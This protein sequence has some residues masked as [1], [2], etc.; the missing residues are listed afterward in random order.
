M[1]M[2]AAVILT[3]VAL[4][5]YRTHSVLMSRESVTVINTDV[6]PLKQASVSVY[7]KH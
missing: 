2:T 1:T 7:N 5:G 6:S 4:I 3:N